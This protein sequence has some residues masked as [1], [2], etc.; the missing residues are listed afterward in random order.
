VVAEA[1]AAPVPPGVPGFAVGA[2]AETLVGASPLA[3]FGFGLYARAELDRASPWSPALVAWVTHDV[4][5][6]LVE[7][8]GNASF[9]LD[10]LALDACFLRLRLGPVEGRGCGAGLIGRLETVGSDTYSPSTRTRPYAVL[11]GS[12]LVAWDVAHF[13]EISGRFGA[14]ASI[15]RDEFQFSPKVFHRVDSVTLVGNLAVGVRFP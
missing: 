7:V 13:L 1:P 9:T 8:Y 10:A 15:I 3:L 14:G 4:R 6:G 12:L 11:G 2:A 5:N